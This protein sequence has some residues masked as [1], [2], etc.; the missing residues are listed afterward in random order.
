MN[1]NSSQVWEAREL[2]P[3]LRQ[4]FAHHVTKPGVGGRQWDKAWN[5]VVKSARH[6][7]KKADVQNYSKTPYSV[8]NRLYLAL[9]NQTPY[10]PNDSALTSMSV[11]YC[12]VVFI[13]HVKTY[14]PYPLHSRLGAWLPLDW[15]ALIEWEEAIER[16]S[17]H[18]RQAVEPDE[19]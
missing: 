11:E 3:F 12:A 5:R 10:S 19:R 6:H 8:V 9:V 1:K 4:V 16:Q 2:I 7:V 13:Q 17:K 15:A 14:G 18:R